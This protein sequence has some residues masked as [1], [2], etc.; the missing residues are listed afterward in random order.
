MFL[1]EVPRSHRLIF[2]R[3]L[4]SPDIVPGARITPV[5]RCIRFLPSDDGR[6]IV[7]K[8][9]RSSAARGFYFQ[10]VPFSF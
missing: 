10:H 6:D 8:T 3:A 4:H 5:A 7:M 2:I 9:F 1:L